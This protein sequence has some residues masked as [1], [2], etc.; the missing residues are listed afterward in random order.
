MYQVKDLDDDMVHTSNDIIDLHHAD[1]VV[2]NENEGSMN[3]YIID[4]FIGIQHDSNNHG[5]DDDIR[6][7]STK[8]NPKGYLYPVKISKMAIRLYFQ[9]NSYSQSNFSTTWVNMVM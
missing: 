1:V 9:Y 3:E 8:I 6:D 4:Y 5:H 2:Y 7:I